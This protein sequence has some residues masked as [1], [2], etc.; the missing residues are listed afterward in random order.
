MLR[1]VAAAAIVGL[2]CA[3]PI[4]DFVNVSLMCL[5]AFLGSSF[6]RHNSKIA[7]INRNPTRSFLGL[8]QT[9]LLVAGEGGLDGEA[10]H[11][12]SQH[13]ATTPH[14]RGLNLTKKGWDA[15][16]INVTS[17]TWLTAAETTCHVWTHQVVVVIPWEL[18]PNWA[19]NNA[20]LWITGGGNQDPGIPKAMDEDVLSGRHMNGIFFMHGMFGASKLEYLLQPRR[21]QSRPG[22]LQLPY[23]R[24][25]MKT[26]ILRLIQR[27]KAAVKVCGYRFVA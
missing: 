25:Q 15:Y 13:F 22:R 21:W 6:A 3:S 7:V 2:A 5:S 23:T 1:S 20:A 10:R 4:W 8:T 27:M 17:G 24:S 9:L 26:A 11:S 12:H 16:I 14:L 19:T 18:T